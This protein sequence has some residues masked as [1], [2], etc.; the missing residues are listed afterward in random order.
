MTEAKRA[1]LLRRLASMRETQAV[2]L[3]LFER[4]GFRSVSMSQIADLVDMPPS[5]IY[6]HFG[7]KEDLV[8]WDH[9][10]EQVATDLAVELASEPPLT[11][12]RLAL[13]SGLASGD[14]DDQEFLLRRLRF[15]NA[16]PALKWA[17]GYRETRRRED[18][19]RAFQA[20]G[21]PQSSAQVLAALGRSC[22]DI[23]LEGWLADPSVSLVN[24]ISTTFDALPAVVEQTLE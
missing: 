6:R 21:V 9:H 2:A 18:L 1:H 19:I 8:V 15:I 11:A 4:E 12:L 22:L 14:Q 20:G 3:Q 13:I 24:R 16:T 17:A 7:S 5:T 23:T 10:D